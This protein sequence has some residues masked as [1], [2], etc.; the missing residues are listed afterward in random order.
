M[1]KPLLSLTVFC[2]V[3]TWSCLS[4][5]SPPAPAAQKTVQ[6]SLANATEPAAPEKE[7]Y[8][9]SSSG[10]RD[11]FYS[12]IEASKAAEKR[13]RKLIVSPLE[14]YDIGEIKLVAVLEAQPDKYALIRLPSGKY[15]SLVV[16]ARVG[17]HSG[18]VISIA[19]SAMTVEE[20]T[21]DVRGNSSKK[22]VT[23]RLRQEEGN[24]Q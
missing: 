10:R 19:P 16:G 2:G 9:Y 4:P 12:L 5:A 14:E 8:N 21:K 1:R 23:L 17:L 22:L 15:F 24:Q 20:I 6:P 18:R 13:Q 7:I 11:P 3:L